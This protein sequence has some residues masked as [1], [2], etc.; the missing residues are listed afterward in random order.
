MT[1]SA[2]MRLGPYEIVAPIGAGGMGEVYR[3]RDTRLDRTVAIKVLPANFSSDAVARERFDREA[4]SIAALNHP[5]I[6]TLYDVRHE[7]VSGAESPI[8]FLVMEYLEGETLAARLARGPLPANLVLRHAIEIAEAL[9]R[10][11]RHGIVHRDLKPGNVMLTKAGAK[12]LDFGLAKAS[13]AGATGATSAVTLE[14]L[15]AAGMIVGTVQYMAPEQVE[16]RDT[17]ARTDI[18]AFGTLVHEMATGRRAFEGRSQATIIAA[19]LDAQPPAISTLQPALPGALDHIVRRCL[20]KDPDERWQSAHDLASELR[21]IAGSDGGATQTSGVTAPARSSRRVS[22]LVAAAGGL[23]IGAVLAAAAVLVLR[24]GRLASASAVVRAV[25]PL[26]AGAAFAQV[27]AR[28]TIGISPDGRFVVFSAVADGVQRLFLRTTDQFDA[29][30]IKG[31]DG[32]TGPFFS[33]DSQWLGFFANGRLLKVPRNGGTPAVICD[34]QDVRGAA[35]GADD[36]IVFAP[37]LDA[38]LW[39]VSASGGGTP[40]V[41]TTPDAQ[42]R[43]K[44]HRFPELLPDGKTVMFTVG[45][46]DIASFAEARI[47]V[48]SLT[49]GPAKTVIQG[50]TTAKYLPT[51]HIVYARDD[52]LMAVPFD[53]QQ[54]AVTGPPVELVGDVSNAM[55]FAHAEYAI[56][57]TGT[58]VYLSGGDSSVRGTLI[59]ADRSGTF[60]PLTQLP[61]RLFLNVMFSPDGQRILTKIGGANDS[62][63]V[64]DMR[65]DSLSRLTFKGNLVW[66]SWSGDGQKIAYSIAGELGWMAADGSGQEETFYRDEYQKNGVRLTP[67]GQAL[68]FHSTRPVTGMDIFTLSIKTRQVTAWL[69]TRSNE[70]SPRISADG[71]WVAYLSDET[72]RQE[73]Y[74]RP[75]QGAGVKWQVSDDGGVSPV[76]SADGHE[77]FFLQGQT[78]MSAVVRPGSAFE[79]DRPK[80]LF[81]LRSSPVGGGDA[82]DVTPDGKRFVFIEGLPKTMPSHANLVTNWFTEVNAQ[83]PRA[84]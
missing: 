72:G 6:C 21:W 23:A 83:A 16:G 73:V 41:V 53:L 52:V 28:T 1:L 55:D 13:A 76:W 12:L 43:E 36:T 19:I 11:H 26:P 25:L 14:P 38:G 79:T 63:W 18:F 49:G 59:S 81:K 31:T 47:V 48:Q 45:T 74:V 80:V 7:V 40:V 44:T 61:P 10:A 35:W 37:R 58:L 5:H 71:R 50:G 22:P 15:T 65:R 54:L 27:N 56:S 24:P 77:L 64:Y 57:D 69:A 62:A 32:A 42:Q 20:A 67:D 4:R 34:V 60:T 66:G 84:R 29:T 51:G 8:D 82:F 33:P 30:P 9:D 2:G 75:L 3:A 39:R 78:L 70:Q 17:D 68:L 46:H